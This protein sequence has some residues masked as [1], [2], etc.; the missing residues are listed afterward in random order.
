MR[1]SQASAEGTVPPVPYLAHPAHPT[2]AWTGN[3]QHIKVQRPNT[4]T[5]SAHRRERPNRLCS[6]GVHVS[7]NSTRSSTDGRAGVPNTATATSQPR[8]VALRRHRTFFGGSLDHDG[9]QCAAVA[10]SSSSSGSTASLSSAATAPAPT[11]SE[12]LPGSGRRCPCQCTPIAAARVVAEPGNNGLSHMDGPT[13][14]ALVTVGAQVSPP[15][16]SRCQPHRRQD[17]PTTCGLWPHGWPTNPR[18]R[19][20]RQPGGQQAV[21]SR[22]SPTLTCNSPVS[23]R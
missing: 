21:V 22:M 3:A 10:M 15:P 13:L 5:A 4:D 7:D 14:C 20:E 9:G 19:R 2:N 12:G 8:D 6:R 17:I 11:P 16:L 1:A 23:L 18:R